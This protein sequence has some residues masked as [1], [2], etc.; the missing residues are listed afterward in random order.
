MARAAKYQIECRVGR[1]IETRLEWLNTASDLNLVE[2]A[3]IR[4]F[5][6][7]GASAVIC[8]D[9]RGIEVF[10]PEVGEA[11][12]ELLRRDNVRIERSAL[13]LSPGGAIFNLQ[14]ERLLREAGNPARRA[15]RNVDHLLAWLGEVLSPEETQ[16]ARQWFGG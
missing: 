15:F 3:L 5:G 8:S 12:I 7:A 4:A 14:V 9:W 2:E 11:L 16:S 13:L 6:Q 10:S 1:L